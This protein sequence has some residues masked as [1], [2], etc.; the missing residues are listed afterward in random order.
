MTVRDIHAY[1]L[2]AQY[3]PRDIGAIITDYTVLFA[4]RLADLFDAHPTGYA[5]ANTSESGAPL[6]FISWWFPPLIA[7]KPARWQHAEVYVDVYTDGPPVRWGAQAKSLAYV[8]AAL[9]TMDVMAISPNV[10]FTRRAWPCWAAQLRRDI[11]L[12]LARAMSYSWD[13]D[14]PGGWDGVG[15]RIDDWL[16]APDD[17]WIIAPEPG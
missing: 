11:R 10:A 8:A 2:T 14:I 15:E 6:L 12:D 3:W 5:L 7:D 16:V 13:A 9:E 4:D 17:Q 1:L